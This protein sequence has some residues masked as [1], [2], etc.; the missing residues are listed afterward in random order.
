MALSTPPQ[1]SDDKGIVQSG[2]NLNARQPK[3]DRRLKG[4]FKQHD[5]SMSIS[6]SQKC[7]GESYN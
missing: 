2:K 4:L 3:R 5:I 7:C 6:G 1:T